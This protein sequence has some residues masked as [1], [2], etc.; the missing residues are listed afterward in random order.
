MKWTEAY[1][2]E[3]SARDSFDK[4]TEE[5]GLSISQGRGIE[6]L[7]AAKGAGYVLQKAEIVRG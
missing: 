7:L 1:N 5:F 3:D 4:L 2:Q 6:R